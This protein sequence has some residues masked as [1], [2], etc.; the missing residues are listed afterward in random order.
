M[1]Q[2]G[3]GTITNVKAATLPRQL[4]L[5][6]NFGQMEFY[7]L[8]LPTAHF[9]LLTHCILYTTVASLGCVPGFL[10]THQ[11]VPGT[12]QFFDKPKKLT[13]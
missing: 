5:S 4:E 13:Q 10:G 6:N 11:F 3:S 7:C 8:L 2:S 1:F 9:V 12:Y